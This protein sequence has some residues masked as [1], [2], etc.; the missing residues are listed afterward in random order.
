MFYIENKHSEYMGSGVRVCQAFVCARV[1]VSL[2]P[3]CLMMYID[4]DVDIVL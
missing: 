4:Q 3:G 2:G 1:A